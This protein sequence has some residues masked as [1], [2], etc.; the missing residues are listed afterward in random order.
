MMLS[1]SDGGVCG[2]TSSWSFPP[3]SPEGSAQRGRSTADLQR[4]EVRRPERGRALRRSVEGV[5]ADCNPL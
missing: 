2:A 1:A 3:E 5:Q 4:G